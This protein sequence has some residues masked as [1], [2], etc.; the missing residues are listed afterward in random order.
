MSSSYAEGGT[1]RKVLRQKIRSAKKCYMVKAREY[2]MIKSAMAMTGP[3]SWPH[4]FVRLRVQKYCP[5]IALFF[6]REAVAV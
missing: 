2:S 5:S 3:R 6:S 4:L 1:S